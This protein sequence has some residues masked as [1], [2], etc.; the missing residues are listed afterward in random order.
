MKLSLMVGMLATAL[1]AGACGGNGTLTTGQCDPRDPYCPGGSYGG[2]ASVPVSGAGT[3]SGGAGYEAGSA[4]AGDNENDDAGVVVIGSSGGSGGGASSSS[5]GSSGGSSGSSS[6][7]G[8]GSAADASTGG[9][10]CVPGNACGGLWECSDNCYTDK[11]CVLN[12]SCTDSSGNGTL[13]CALT[14]P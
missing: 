11:C 1:G 4:E 3:D 14:C 5:S 9:G 2:G 13:N 12:C 8:G 10:L 6:S 7:S